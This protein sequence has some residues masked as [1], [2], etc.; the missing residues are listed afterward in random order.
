MVSKD[1]T[2][3]SDTLPVPRRG[4]LPWLVVACFLLPSS[5]GYTQDEYVRVFTG[6]HYE[7]A[8][9]VYTPI[10]SVPN[11]ERFDNK[12]SSLIY[13][14]APGRV[15]ALYLDRNYE[16]AMLELHGTGY[17]VEIPDLG[18]Y[19]RNLSSLRWDNT[20][21][22][23][24]NPEGSFA[25]LYDRESFTGRRLTVIFNQNIPD[26]RGIRDEEGRQGFENSVSSARWLIP[27]GWNLVLYRRRNF[28]G[29]AVELRGSGMMDSTSTLAKFSSRASSLRWEPTNPNGARGTVTIPQRSR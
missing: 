11:L 2:W 12:I 19:T 17:R 25:R 15:A 22:Q 28:Q 14:M 6:K 26:L 18:L 13:K 8:Q 1:P 20:G 10:R 7:G 4:C 24:T 21:G 9:T 29:E 23:I 27:P 16:G 5:A 3:R